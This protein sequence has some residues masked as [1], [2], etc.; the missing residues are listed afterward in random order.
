VWAVQ[1]ERDC[2]IVSKPM[3]KRSATASP[4]IGTGFYFE[5]A[6]APKNGSEI[7][8]TVPHTCGLGACCLPVTIAKRPSTG[9]SR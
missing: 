1:R 4:E 3:G 8:L 7:L 2:Y 5:S 6:A 9:I